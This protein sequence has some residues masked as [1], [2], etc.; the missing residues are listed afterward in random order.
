MTLI[1]SKLLGWYHNKTSPKANKGLFPKILINDVRNLPIINISLEK[2]QPFIEKADKMLSLNKELQDLS[3]K[4]Q[5]MLL[6]K[7]ELDKLS[8]KLQEW[9][10]LDFSEFIKELKRLKVKLSLLQE[11]DWEEFF[12]VEKSKAVLIDSEIK[13][14]DKEIDSMVY[15]LYELTDEEIKIVEE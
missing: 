6:R 1:N 8:T 10:L 15:K 12:L 2:Q 5:R 9:Y 14:T 3:Q 13:S 7:F 11:S 4:F